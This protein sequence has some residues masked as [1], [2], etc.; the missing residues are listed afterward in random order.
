MK[1]IFILSM[2]IAPVV[3][4]A[5]DPVGPSA[6]SGT[7]VVATASAPY[8][9]ATE[10]TGDSTTVVSASYVKGAYNDAIAA[11]NKVNADKQAQ[12]FFNNGKNIY[13]INSEVKNIINMDGNNNNDD[14]L[15]TQGAVYRALQYKQDN[16]RTYD[17]ILDEYSLIQSTVRTAADLGTPSD[18]YLLT[19]KAVIGAINDHRINA[20]TTWGDD[21]NPTQL[22]LTTASN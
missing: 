19:E 5:T 8:A 13:N 9:T 2:L 21:N 22:T 12:L 4:H 17:E 15:V 7:P 3:A 20:V 6:A 16:L 1:K 11:V 10:Q 18:S 14:S